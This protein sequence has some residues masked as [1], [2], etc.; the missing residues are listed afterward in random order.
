MAK[1]KKATVAEKKDF[2]VQY[3]EFLEKKYIPLNKNIKIVIAIGIIAGIAALFYFLI[4]APKQKDIKKLTAENQ[5]LQKKVDEAAEAEKQQTE[6]EKQLAAK[7]EEF[8]EIAKIFP[9]KQDIPDL[10]SSISDLGKRAGLDFNVFQP[11]QEALAEEGFYFKIPISIKLT[12][13]Y[14]NIGYFLGEVSGLERLVTVDNITLSSPKEVEGGEM[15]LTS[16][17]DLLTYRQKD[18]SSAEEDEKKK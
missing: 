2:S 13:P 15:L 1:N 11:K 12:G 16:S 8:E 3:E 7:K 5:G 6:L 9:E 14:H 17:C 4:F 10:L 18:E